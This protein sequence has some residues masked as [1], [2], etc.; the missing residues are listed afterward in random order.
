MLKL[1]HLLNEDEYQTPFQRGE[2]D[3][4]DAEADQK[5]QDSFL[6][7][8]EQNYSRIKRARID[9]AEF[10]NDVMDLLSIYK[11]KTPGSATTMDF[12]DAFL[13][14]YPYSKTY[15]GWQGTYR[16]VRNNLNRMLQHAHSIQA[17]DTSNYGYR[18]S[19]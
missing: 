6:T 9:M 4:L 5:I 13:E 2:T 18:F 12:I 16:D 15:S 10:K 17:G 3:G 11:D 19:K 1:K 7:K 8:L 14:L